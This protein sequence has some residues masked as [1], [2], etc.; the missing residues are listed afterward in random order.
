MD[1]S[2][3]KHALSA[4]IEQ[5]QDAAE[6]VVELSAQPITLES[7]RDLRREAVRAA[8]LSRQIERLLSRRQ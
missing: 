6:M 8:G 5:M 7:M 1:H 4:A 3:T 2:P